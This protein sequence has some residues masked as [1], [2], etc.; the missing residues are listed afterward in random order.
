[1]ITI[2]LSPRTHPDLQNAHRLKN[3]KTF[4][5]HRRTTTKRKMENDC[6]CTVRA[7]GKSPRNRCRFNSWVSRANAT[8]FFVLWIPNRARRCVFTF[9]LF[10]VNWA[11]AFDEIPILCFSLVPKR[12][13]E[14]VDVDGVERVHAFSP[15]LVLSGVLPFHSC[16]CLHQFL[17]HEVVDRRR[18]TM[19]PNN[20]RNAKHSLGDV[21]PHTTKACS[22]EWCETLHAANHV[23]KC[24]AKAS[25]S[26][27]WDSIHDSLC[28]S[29]VV[30]GMRTVRS[31]S[32]RCNGI[33]AKH[34]ADCSVEH[35]VWIDA[36]FVCEFQ[37]RFERLA[38]KRVIFHDE[39]LESSICISMLSSHQWFMM[40]A[41]ISINKPHSN[42]FSRQM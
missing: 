23:R 14:S 28:L 19:K 11:N 2:T 31:E 10:D 26:L 24:V 8:C 6:N 1:M 42:V 39:M 38:I 18:D 41:V 16:P 20:V 5:R 13:V 9:Q 27:S 25:L 15:L 17:C 22:F 21:E 12:H 30:F 32:R 3:H 4:G 7:S 37:L 33:C 36:A 34:H 35:R 40:H 29:L